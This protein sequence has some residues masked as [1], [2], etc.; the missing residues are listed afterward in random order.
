MSPHTGWEDLANHVLRCHFSLIVPSRQVCGLVV[1]DEIQYH[2][3]KQIIVFDD[4]LIHKAFNIPLWKYNGEGGCVR[5]GG[6]GSE[7]DEDP[8]TSNP[9]VRGRPPIECG[10]PG[11][12]A[13]DKGVKH[14]GVKDGG[15]VSPLDVQVEVDSGKGGI[16]GI[17]SVHSSSAQDLSL[18]TCIH[19]EDRSAD[20]IVLIV[21]LLRPSHLPRGTATGGH[22]P[23]L[24]NFIAQFR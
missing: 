24:D 6:G 13:E 23:E 9:L 1:D 22:T 19:P 15:I 20:R 17:S 14:E 10:V 7:E 3:E 12:P 8:A 16:S 18:A 5:G 2:H 11:S 4:S 21:D